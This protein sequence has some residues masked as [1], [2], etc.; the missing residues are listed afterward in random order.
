MSN[1]I[2]LFAKKEE[3]TEEVVIE[4]DEVELSFEETMK[5]NKENAERLKKERSRENKNVIRGHGLKKKH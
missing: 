1:V 2:N 5:R 3:L 4:A